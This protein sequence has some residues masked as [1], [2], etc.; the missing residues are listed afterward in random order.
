MKGPL[1]CALPIGDCD[2]LSED[3]P[4]LHT[5]PNQPT[6]DADCQKHRASSY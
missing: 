2:G 3:K 5:G 4:E 6:A 1:C